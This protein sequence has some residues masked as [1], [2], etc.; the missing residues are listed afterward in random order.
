MIKLIWAMDENRVIG[1]DNLLPWNY[2]SDIKYYK[3]ITNN[4]IVLMGKN[5]YYSMKKYYKTWPYEKVYVASHSLDD[6]SDAIVVKDLDEF[7]K[8][9]K[10]EVFV[11]GGSYIFNKALEYADM[12]YITYILA[13]HDGDTYFPKFDLNDYKLTNYR[14]EDKLIFAVYQRR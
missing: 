14:L 1:K 8:N 10:E 11:L 12:L 5:T 6:L 4:K 13:A 9:N 2:P 3:A 7:F